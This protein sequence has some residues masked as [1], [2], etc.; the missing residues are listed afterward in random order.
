MTTMQGNLQALAKDY[1]AAQK[2]AEKLNQRGGKSDLNKVANASSDF[3]NASSQWTSQAPY[4][5]EALQAVDES[6]CNNLRD[7]LT[8]YETLEVDLVERN[9]KTAENTLNSLLNVE[10]SNEIR[11]FAARNTG[12][13]T[14][15]TG[16]MPPAMQRPN[17]SSR[18]GPPPAA[19]AAQAARLAPPSTGGDE[20]DRQRSPSG[21]L[22]DF[23]TLQSNTNDHSR[24]R[25][26][27]PFRRLET[28]I[29][30]SSWPSKEH[31]A[32]TR[33]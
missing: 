19:S 28:W 27:E 26:E 25:E 11:T 15:A 3:E 23:E 1:D 21:W 6:R 2:K 4:V 14:G 13:G 31:A 22:S 29:R 18:S 12:S 7:L 17:R 5:F 20:L 8:Q 16:R 32:A 9:R 33:T 10:T 30:H 24:R